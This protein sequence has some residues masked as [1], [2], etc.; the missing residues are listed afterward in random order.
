ML[1][2][3]NR[4]K[5]LRDS[6]IDCQIGDIDLPHFGASPVVRKHFLFSGRVQG[7]GFRFEVMRLAERLELSGWVSNLL[8]GD[9]EA[10]LQ[11]PQEKISFLLHYMNTLKRISIRS[12]EEKEIPPIPGDTEFCIRN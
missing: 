10:E 11:G 8:D 9:V 5:R 7:V 2:F 1:S 3:I 4:L 6:Y 12:I